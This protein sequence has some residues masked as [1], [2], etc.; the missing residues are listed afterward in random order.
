V[1]DQGFSVA[2]HK[3]PGGNG[4]LTGFGGYAALS[5]LSFLVPGS[6]SSLGF[7]GARGAAGLHIKQKSAKLQFH[8]NSTIPPPYCL[9]SLFPQLASRFPQSL[10][11]SSVHSH[12]AKALPQITA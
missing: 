11:I 9:P 8:L 5:P 3:F 10:P 2:P 4:W 1:L 6:G 7:A 12:L